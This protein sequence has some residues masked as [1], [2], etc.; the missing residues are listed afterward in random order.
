MLVRI[1]SLVPQLVGERDQNHGCVRGG[2]F[3][4]YFLRF[5]E[6]VILHVWADQLRWTPRRV[7]VELDPPPVDAQSAV[8]PVREPLHGVEEHVV[9]RAGV[10]ERDAVVRQW[11]GLSRRTL[12]SL[13][14]D[15]VV[16]EMS[17]NPVEPLELPHHGGADQPKALRAA[18]EISAVAPDQP[19][20]GGQVKTESSRSISKYKRSENYL[21]RSRRRAASPRR[22]GGEQRLHSALFHDTAT[23]P[24]I[25]GTQA[26]HVDSRGRRRAAA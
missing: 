11:W 18:Q 21:A 1:C 26:I 19:F 24:M 10:H 25:C 5:Y 15:E 22:G 13:D 2:Q 7:D 6:P 16:H 23:D 3:F 17:V 9:D 20:R 12:I 4:W 8:K 14:V